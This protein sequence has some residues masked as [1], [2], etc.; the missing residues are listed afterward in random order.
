MGDSCI[1]NKKNY[2]ASEV[3]DFTVQGRI[4]STYVLDAINT[5]VE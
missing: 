3:N 2:T 5:W 1:R 4:L